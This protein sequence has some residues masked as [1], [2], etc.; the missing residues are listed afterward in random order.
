MSP[1]PTT[2][3]PARESIR[4]AALTA[5]WVKVFSAGAVDRDGSANE[6]PSRA[7]PPD[8]TGRCGGDA[9]AAWK[10][11]HRTQW[12]TLFPVPQ[13]PWY[14]VLERA[15][16]EILAS[17]HLP[18]MALNLADTESLSPSHPAMARLYRAA[19]R[20]LD[21]RVEA[22]E[23]APTDEDRLEVG[24]PT[25]ETS[26]TAAAFRS[27]SL[28]RAGLKPRGDV[29]SSQAPTPTEALVIDTLRQARAF[30]S[31]G[32]S[33]AVSM[34]P[35][36]QAFAEY[37][38]DMTDRAS[39]FAPPGAPLKDGAEFDPVEKSDV[40]TKRASAR[41][42]VPEIEKAYPGY[43]VFTS[44]WDE[45][46][47]ASHWFNPGD[48]ESLEQ[49]DLI[50]RN[51][52]RRLAHRMQRRLMAA[53]LRY[54]SFDREEGLLD[55]K[56]LTRLLSDTCNCRIFRT[57]HEAPAPEACV[58]LLVDQSGSM[59][60]KRQI[61]A[62]L[63]IDLAVH[64]MEACGVRCEVLGYT[65]RFGPD[66]PLTRRWREE[67]GP[68]RPGRLNALRHIVYKTAEQPW[69]RVRPHLGLMLRK[70][71]GRENIDG[72]SLYWAARRLIFRPEKRKILMVLS[73]GAPYDEATAGAN[74][75]PLLENHLRAVI[76]DIE[77]SP[78]HLV[79]IG[80][81][82]EAGRFYRRALT[83]SRPESVAEVLFEGM[84]ELLALPGSTRPQSSP[85]RSGA[86]G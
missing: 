32:R 60:G 33:F 86:A 76:A 9:L 81:G 27:D 83:L 11:W 35:L 18:G 67:G 45:V 68:G 21:G 19:R 6:L 64:T 30:L 38:D 70:G 28:E 63:A 31:D 57:E 23:S 15:R 34:L 40:D 84:A 50:D 10:R 42:G 48:L 44:A 80:A 43:S 39:D 16:V 54:W 62:A 56:R 46:L 59:S 7:A 73:D 22:G 61:M 36:A 75:R 66:N 82:R 13:R 74:G 8:P 51:L 37:F 52:V 77:S 29:R 69:R 25:A 14:A 71:F 3:N 1:A 79:A 41:D 49:I 58:V 2:C 85:Y 55:S 26:P 72:E 78:I 20:I 47:P 53:R 24:P 17:R 4:T 65:T 12:D 5:T